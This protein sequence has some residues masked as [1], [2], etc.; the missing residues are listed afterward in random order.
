MLTE[1]SLDAD[2]RG[3]RGFLTV[4]EGGDGR[5]QN[6]IVASRIGAGPDWT[7]QRPFPDWR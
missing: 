2:E 5:S 3:L 6:K 1:E 7:K 4:D